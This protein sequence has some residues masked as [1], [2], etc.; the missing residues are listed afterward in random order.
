M[1]LDDGWLEG[2]THAPRAAPK[3]GQYYDA[4]Y[5][6]RVSWHTME[7]WLTV[8]GT[9]GHPAP[10]QLWASPRTRLKVQSIPLIWGGFATYAHSSYPYDPDTVTNHVQVELEGFAGQTG[11]WP[12]EWLD[13][14]ADEVLVPIMRFYRHHGIGFDPLAG[15]DI[16]SEAMGGSA[17]DDAP[18]RMGWNEWA[19]F[20]AQGGHRHIPGNGDRWDPGPLDTLHIGRRA[21]AVI[22]GGQAPT[23]TP[24]PKLKR[25][26]DPDMQGQLR[27]NEDGSPAIF[28][29][30]LM[31]AR[32]CMAYDFPLLPAGSAIGVH[33]ARPELDAKGHRVAQLVWKSGRSTADAYW[34]GQ[35]ATFAT[36]TSGFHSIVVPADVP[37]MVPEAIL[38]AA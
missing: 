6:A 4:G 29:W 11:T 37:V 21:L 14:V 9:L 30:D 22:G 24:P 3:D 26:G 1:S 8:G 36:S 25:R 20:N 31:G 2:W 33:Q 34:W 17:A 28:Q 23:P 7:G 35:Q 16:P 19:R 27:R 15:P 5:P 18:Q 12:A 10:P 13:W 38:P 32:P